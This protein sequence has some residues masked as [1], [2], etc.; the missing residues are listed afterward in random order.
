MG[1]GRVIGKL[2]VAG[3]KSL[4]L[5]KAKGAQHIPDLAG[6][7]GRGGVQTLLE[8]AA[9]GT[10]AVLSQIHFVIAENSRHMIG[11]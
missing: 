3:R 1:L 9:R 7:G 4:I 5:E 11:Y 6:L 2:E 10:T 8:A